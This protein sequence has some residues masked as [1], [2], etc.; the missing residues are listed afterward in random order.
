MLAKIIDIQSNISR[1]L[2]AP[3]SVT[4]RNTLAHSSFF[5]SNVYLRYTQD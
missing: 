1:Y 5:V 3:F 4:W 2:L